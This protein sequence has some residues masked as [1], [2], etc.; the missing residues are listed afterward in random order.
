MRVTLVDHYLHEAQQLA[1]LPGQFGRSR[2]QQF[3]R[4]S[5]Y[6]N[7]STDEA[8]KPVVDIEGAPVAAL[9]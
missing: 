5:E 3:K 2:G 6:T 9:Q 4:L 7:Q 8:S 1:E